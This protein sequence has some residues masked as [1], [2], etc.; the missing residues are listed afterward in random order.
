MT[1]NVR[2]VRLQA[3]A[4]NTT[5]DFTISGFG[6]PDA[7]IVMSGFGDGSW[8]SHAQLTIGGF[9]GTNQNCN[10]Y[11]MEN[12]SAVNTGQSR[13]QSSTSQVVRHMKDVSENRS[14]IAS[15]FSTITDGVRLTWLGDTSFRPWTTVIMLKGDFTVFMGN[16]TLP[17]TTTKSM[18][19]TGVNP[20]FILF[21]N[22]WRGADS[23]GALGRF[24]MG[25]AHDTGSGIDVV[26]HNNRF[27]DGNPNDFNSTISDAQYVTD[28]NTFM[29]VNSMGTE[30]FE[31]ETFSNHFSNALHF[32]AFE[33]NENIKVFDSATVTT[34]VDWDPVVTT[35]T[36]QWCFM[37]PTA[38]INIPENDSGS[39]S[40]VESYGMYS[41]TEDDTESGVYVIHE[42]GS[43]VNQFAE[44]R[45]DTRFEI[46]QVQSTDSENLVNG[47]SP[48]FDSTGIVFAAANFTEAGTAYQQIGFMI[49]EDSSSVVITD[50]NT[51]ESWNDG[52][53]GLV[54]TGTGFV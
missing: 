50:V 13:H 42:N 16:D 20:N 23:A 8:V 17:S 25:F 15:A 11:G 37:L 24:G 49:E 34:N 2:Q 29:D 40:S 14:A 12:S 48:T 38:H 36:P 1:L 21:F 53:T 5:Q 28:Q 35:F 18:T 33:F 52:D 4:T 32:M 47:N 46:N 27:N 45:T 41:N 9:D 3:P 54:I 51:T 43:T 31:I 10:G 44:S 22:I 7:C 30:T 19:T 26:G 39:E 6:E